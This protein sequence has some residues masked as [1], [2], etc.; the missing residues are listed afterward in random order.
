MK[1]RCNYPDNVLKAVFGASAKAAEPE[2]LKVFLVKF[3]PQ[4]LA[5]KEAELFFARFCGKTTLKN[6]AVAL[7]ITYGDARVLN[8]AVLR[9]IRHPSTS[10]YLK[11]YV[12]LTD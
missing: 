7:G 9:K 11:A 3:I 6:I 2:K 10:G 1:N 5:P 12:E 4:R 8:E